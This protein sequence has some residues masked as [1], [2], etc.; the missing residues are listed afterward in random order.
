MRMWIAKLCAGSVVALVFLG[1]G[2][3]IGARRPIAT[4]P[5]EG[6]RF[7]ATNKPGF[8]FDTKLGL[9]CDMDG[10]DVP[11]GITLDIPRCA[12]LAKR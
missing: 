2:V 10:I 5:L 4:S 12:S 3:L 7:V 6:Q 9:E 8:A 11:R 1:A